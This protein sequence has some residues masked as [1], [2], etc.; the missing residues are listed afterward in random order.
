MKIIA[1]H[2]P[3]FHEIPENSNWWGDGFTEWVNVKKAKKMFPFHNQPRKPINKNY[4]NLLDT[5]TMEYQMQLAKKYG[6]YG[7][8][9][10]HYWFGGQKLLEKPVEDILNNPNATL[11][12]CLAWANESWTRTWH[13]AK[14]EKEVL[15]RQTY[16]DEKEWKE[17]FEYLLPFF[18]DHR[19]IKDN[20][21]PVFLIYRAGYMG[22]INQMFSLW[23]MLAKE[24]GFEGISFVKMKTGDDRELKSKYLQK[25][26]DFEP[27]RTKRV[28]ILGKGWKNKIREVLEAK[29]C[30]LGFFNWLFCE[31]LDYD[32]INREMLE[33]KHSKGE[34]RSIF[35]NYDDTPRRGRKGLVM[36]GSTPLKFEKYLTSSLEKSI[37]E[38]NEFFF[39]NAWNEWGEGNYLEPDVKYGY[40]YL[41]AIKNAQNNIK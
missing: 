28:H 39:I 34:Y 3:Q 10:Y 14:G 18:T 32:T 21:K 36:R 7:F 23:D 41:H 15:I 19:Y 31:F 33:T 17:H 8:C 1:F 27:G 12:F 38:G 6:V 5:K 26:V 24:N 40:S 25:S 2:L 16:G 9:F 35:V 37:E 13:G 30:D 22:N 11:P 20:G 4:Y 29:I